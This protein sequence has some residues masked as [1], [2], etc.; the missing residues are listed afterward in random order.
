MQKFRLAIVTAIAAVLFAAG[1]LG[2][3]HAQTGTARPFATGF[4]VQNLGSSEADITIE[5]YEENNSTSVLSY[6]ATI[7]ANGQRTYAVLDGS[8]NPDGGNNPSLPANFRGSAVISSDQQVAAIV[9]IV[10]PDIGLSFGGEAYVGFDSGAQT[11]S[12]PL[13]FK[14]FAGFNTFFNVQNAGSATANVTVTYSTGDTETATIPPNASV[15]FDQ[16]TN[17]DLPDGFN[18]SA[19]I[20]SDQDIV[21]AAVQVGPDTVFA[22]NGFTGNST[23][24]VFPLVNANNAN[25]FTGIALQN[26]GDQPTDVTVEYEPSIA[27]TACSETITIPAQSSRFF[28]L[29]AFSASP[30]AG[31]EGTNDC[32]NGAT[33][34]GSG[35]VTANSASQPLVAIVNQL[36]NVTN[37]GGAYASFDP[38]VASDTVVYPLAQDRFFGFFS[39]FS[40]VNV[41]S[42]SATVT[43]TFSGTSATQS[44]TVPAGGTFT[45]VQQG[46]IQSNYN[47]SAVCSASGGQIVGIANQV[48]PTAATDTFF[49]YEGS[50]N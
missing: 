10:S 50:N 27:G 24:P 20:E 30:A 23:A 28:A 34:V 8:S 22:Y 9:N 25:F 35:R 4:Q 32:A 17:A 36:N 48:N 31:Y 11:V 47:G 12:L 5:F 15:R 49:V 42:S 13:L 26:V 45:P 44:E 14:N 37:K 18:G 38:S 7:P 46:N 16:Q 6:P 21:A 40:L 43:C 39:G 33:F 29:E 1:G 2:A 19:I 41:G 3:V